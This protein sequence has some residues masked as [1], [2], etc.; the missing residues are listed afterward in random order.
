MSVEI[1]DLSAT[2]DDVAACQRVKAYLDQYP[3]N[4]PWW[5]TNRHMQTV[6]STYARRD[7]PMPFRKER[8]DTPDDDFLDIYHLDNDPTKPR[9]VLLHGLEGSAKSKYIAGVCSQLREHGWNATVIEFRTCGG[10][11]NRARRTYHIGETTDLALVIET[12]VERNPDQGLYLSGVSL[13]GNVTM[14]W[15]GE[16]GDELPSQVKAGA[17]VSC[18]FDLLVSGPELDKTGGGLY[19][20]YFIPKLRKKAL[21]KAELYPD[22][23]DIEAVRRAKTFVDF[24]TV[25]TAALHG[26][27][28]AED[29][30]ARN[31]CGQ[32]L[33]GIRRPA[34]ILA[35]AD[36]PF[37]PGSTIPHGEFERNPYLIPQITQQGGHV[38]FV[39]GPHPLA[40]RYWAEDQVVR[41]FL[42]TAEELTANESYK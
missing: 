13:G 17:A 12:L 24:D 40:Q 31:A 11:M 6:W 3:F 10:E 28:D 36:D 41:Y 32:F 21:A 35:S 26:F 29:Y 8:L 30:W 27:K 22:A 25:V 9:A 18:P 20:Y 34:M 1:E 14:K 7:N 16:L 19:L 33:K 15:F 2:P 42:K 4:A 23:L 38:G 37:N 5:L 39:Y